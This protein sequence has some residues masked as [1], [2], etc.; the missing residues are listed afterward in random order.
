MRKIFLLAFLPLL[1]LLCPS[2]SLVAKAA[3]TSLPPP[4]G[5]V[6]LPLLGLVGDFVDPRTGAEQGW[7]TSDPVPLEEKVEE[8][9]KTWWAIEIHL[10]EGDEFKGYA[11]S[12]GIWIGPG[13]DGGLD[14]ASFSYSAWDGNWSVLK[15]GS[16]RIL[17]S[18]EAASSFD[19][20]S[21]G[22]W[23]GGEEVE[24]ELGK[25]VY[26]RGEEVIGEDE[27]PLGSA[28]QTR[29]IFQEGLVLDGWYFDPEFTLPV[30]MAIELTGTIDVYGKYSPAGPD[31]VIE[32]VGEYTHYHYW[33]SASGAESV[34]PGSEMTFEEDLLGGHHVA[35]IPGEYDPTGILFHDNQG[36]QTPDMNI[37]PALVGE[38]GDYSL[39]ATDSG[40]LPEE[41]SLSRKEALSFLETWETDIVREGDI[42][43]LSEDKESWDALRASYEGLSASARN[44]V[45]PVLTVGDVTIG[46]TMGYLS[47]LIDGALPGEGLSPYQG[48]DPLALGLG[49]G[50]GALVLIG[51]ATL[52]I[53][54]RKKGKEETE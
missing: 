45:D 6:E 24:V 3:D 41:A 12:S 43:W 15:S 9:G 33:N 25:I 18:E 37:D 54:S 11:P 32:H 23:K 7:N 53:R 31:I 22:I 8:E 28:K 16:Y 27:G 10:D 14:P 2:P 50:A 39:F 36:N 29:W 49:I 48:V 1:G 47:L 13:K 51:A 30:S 26:H 38:E 35:I 19:G 5:E 42:C 46:D 40:W 52:L 44:L 34:W 20:E 4:G 21:A 17:L